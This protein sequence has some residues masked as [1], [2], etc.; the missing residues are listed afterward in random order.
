MIE[1]NN[2]NKTYH[3]KNILNNVNLKIEDGSITL[4]TGENGSGKSTLLKIIGEIIYPDN[5]K[6]INLNYISSFLP[7]KFMLPR[8]LKVKYYINFLQNLYLIKLD[9]YVEFLNV[10][11]DK[12]IKELSKGNL[13][14]L[15][16]L[17]VISSKNKLILLDEPTEGMDKELKKK[18]ISV[19]SKLHKEGH[20]II[21]STHDKS[22][23]FRMNPNI[24]KI[25]GGNVIEI[26]K[27]I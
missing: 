24:I 5:K 17:Y 14:K 6:S 19:I 26:I 9:S 4:L 2:L 15:G 13:Q 23:Y 22:D 12:K 16:L 7:E 11:L 10:P 3:K 27:N 21:I 1:I 25:E 18:F 20:T 8:N